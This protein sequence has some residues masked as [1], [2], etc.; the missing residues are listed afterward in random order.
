[1][2]STYT[3]STVAESTVAESTL[4][5]KKKI[6]FIFLFKI[7]VQT[8]NNYLQ[9]P[10]FYHDEIGESFN[11]IAIQAVV[12]FFRIKHNSADPALYFEFMLS[13]MRTINSRKIDTP[14]SSPFTEE[15][16]S[17]MKEMSGED[18]SSDEYFEA[19]QKLYSKN[20]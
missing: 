2:S 8:Y 6:F 11:I 4:L 17:L 16:M 3:D 15:E 18:M 19:L 9:N 14:E 12:C 20:N 13:Y 7:F 10:E 5:E 1:M